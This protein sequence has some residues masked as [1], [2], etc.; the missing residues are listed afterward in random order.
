MPVD[1]A[2]GPILILQG[3]LDQA[4]TPTDTACLLEVLEGDGAE[5]QVCTDA[6]AEHMDI[7]ARQASVAVEWALAL[8]RGEALPPCAESELPACE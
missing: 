8:A 1:P 4:S 6:A 7:T 2:S 5:V 3:M